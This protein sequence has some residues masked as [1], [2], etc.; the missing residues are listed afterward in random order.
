VSPIIIVPGPWPQADIEFHGAN[1][2]SVLTNKQL[3]LG[4]T[5][6]GSQTNGTNVVIGTR[7]ENQYYYFRL[8]RRLL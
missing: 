8:R 1:L 2:A 4:A 5:A 7:R 6:S 3:I